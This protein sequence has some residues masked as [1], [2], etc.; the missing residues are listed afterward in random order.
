KEVLEVPSTLSAVRP[1]EPQLRHVSVM[2]SQD[3]GVEAVGE[4]FNHLGAPLQLHPVGAAPVVNTDV[5]GKQLIQLEEVG[6]I[7]ATEIPVLESA[8]V[9]QVG[10][11]LK[12]VGHQ[13]PGLTPKRW[14]AHQH[15]AN[16]GQLRV[17]ER[18]KLTS[19]SRELQLISRMIV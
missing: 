1:G 15:C 4:K 7:D 12:G 16:A 19:L 10:E 18:T 3:I 11:L 9:L 14:H 2:A 6:R 13:S 8:E 5:L 17:Y